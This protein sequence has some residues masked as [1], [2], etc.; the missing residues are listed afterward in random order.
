MGNKKRTDIRYQI[1]DNELYAGTAPDLPWLSFISS[2]H[3][4]PEEQHSHSN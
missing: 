3:N 4:A 2:L 1:L